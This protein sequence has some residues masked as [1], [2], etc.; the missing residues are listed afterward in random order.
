MDK[1][2]VASSYPESGGKWLNVQME[3][4]DEQCTSR[5]NNG[6][7]VLQYLHQLH[8]QWD[9][10]HPQHICRW[11]QVVWCGQHPWGM[12]CHSLR[13]RQAEAVGP[14]SHSQR[15]LGLYFFFF[16]HIVGTLLARND[17]QLLWFISFLLRNPQSVWCYSSVFHQCITVNFPLSRIRNEDWNSLPSMQ[18]LCA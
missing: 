4:T 1:E 8:L 12:E 14:I 13:P 10:V 5:V 7:N 2:L 9:W 11:R 3:M 17:S 16:K 6:T 18:L 15:F